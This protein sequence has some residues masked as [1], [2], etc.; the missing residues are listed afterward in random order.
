MVRGQQMQTRP[1]LA[2]LV[3]LAFAIAQA[4]MVYFRPIDGDEGL[5]L[6]VFDEVVQGR[7][8]YADFFYP[9][10]PGLPFVYYAWL[11][12]VSGPSPAGLRC[13]S[14]VF[15]V[16]TLG[17]VL[18]WGRV[19]QA[20]TRESV[21][22]VVLVG[23]SGLTLGWA[24]TLKT[25]PFCIFAS[26][27]GVVALSAWR[28]DDRRPSWLPFAA[29]LALGAAGGTRLFYLALLPI[30]LAWVAFEARARAGRLSL[31]APLFLIV[32][33]LIPLV[34]A[35][36]VAG[37]HFRSFYFETVT[38]H[39]YRNET[40]EMIGNWKQKLDVVI[41]LAKHVSLV[42]PL[43]LIVWKLRGRAL[44][45]P[46]RRDELLALS[47]AA[48]LSILQF[49]PTPVATQYYVNIVPFL[50]F[51]AL[52]GLR[53]LLARD[54][55]RTRRRLS[56]ALA[57]YLAF[58]PYEAW[59]LEIKPMAGGWC[60]YTIAEWN[61]LS[62]TIESLTQPSDRVLAWWPGI[63]TAA[64]R[65]VAPGFENNFPYM[66]SKRLPVDVRRAFSIV[67]DE[68]TIAM[69]ERREPALVVLRRQ[70]FLP[71]RDVYEPIVARDY[72]L[73]AERGDFLLYARRAP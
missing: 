43:A 18:A 58:A 23:G 32:G 68:Q 1:A 70:F 7:T 50:A 31:G 39:G 9:Q 34:P 63:V 57:G 33:A 25:Y 48:T 16:A 73:V 54:D 13:L 11:K 62:R 60:P 66:A 29:G 72:R 41:A 45:S 64:H 67:D 15:N 49:L 26:V 14:L 47:F 69:I 4:F 28:A 51:G 59:Y 5:Y 3:A 2:L 55:D 42:A 27:A 17:L 12:W 56:V 20:T 71:S 35:A 21:A 22:L 46:E 61:E 38:F 30:A 40:S 6:T 52:A 8:L 19:K 36:W 24:S 37:S 65:R 44:L 53:D 10:F